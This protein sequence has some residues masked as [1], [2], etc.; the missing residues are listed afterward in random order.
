M[1]GVTEC[2]RAMM[3]LEKALGECI[4]QARSAGLGP[5]IR[6]RRLPTVG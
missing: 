6:L 3:A 4:I 5:T 1:S 2:C